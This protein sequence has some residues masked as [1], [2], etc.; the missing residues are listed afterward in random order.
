[1][2]RPPNDL[3]GVVDAK[4]LPNEPRGLKLPLV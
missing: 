4:G 3:A 2:P 1:M